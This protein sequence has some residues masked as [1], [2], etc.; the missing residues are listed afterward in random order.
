MTSFAELQQE[1]ATFAQ[2]FVAFRKEYPDPQTVPL[3]SAG[4]DSEFDYACRRINSS[5]NCLG[6]DAEQLARQS[7]NELPAKPDSVTDAFI[8]PLKAVSAE[9][10]GETLSLDDIHIAFRPYQQRQ[11]LGAAYSAFQGLQTSLSIDEDFKIIERE[12][13]TRSRLEEWPPLGKREDLR[14]LITFDCPE[15]GYSPAELTAEIRWR[16]SKAHE[17]QAT[18]QFSHLAGHNPLEAKKEFD[19]NIEGYVYWGWPTKENAQ[20]LQTAFNEQFPSACRRAARNEALAVMQ[21]SVHLG[22]FSGS[23]RMDFITKLT[24]AAGVTDL[25]EIFNPSEKIGDHV[26]T[27]DECVQRLSLAV[28]NHNAARN[29]SNSLGYR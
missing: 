9:V 20:K 22:G 16:M 7:P 24:Q 6:R 11:R 13:G 1:F 27:P 26:L 28:Q 5:L 12:I 19:R 8:W 18:Q 15:W 25:K 17:T 4:R 29:Y 2:K 21:T 10:D 3:P 14:R 23:S